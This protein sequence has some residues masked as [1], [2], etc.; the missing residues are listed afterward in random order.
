MK[1]HL[2][3]KWDRNEI[4]ELHDKLKGA[5]GNLVRP[6]SQ[7]GKQG[8]SGLTGKKGKTKYAPTIFL[9]IKNIKVL[10][11]NINKIKFSFDLDGIP[12]ANGGQGGLGGDG[13][14]G[15]NGRDAWNGPYPTCRRGGR[16]GGSG[17]SPGKGGR[18]GDAGCGGNGGR[19][20]LYTN[21]I[22][23]WEILYRSD[24][25]VKG[26]GHGKN[27]DFPGGK[28]GRPGAAGKPGAKGERGANA[29]NCSSVGDRGVP[30]KPSH[31][32]SEWRKW[33]LGNGEDSSYGEDGFFQ[34]QLLDNITN[35]VFNNK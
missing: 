15:V 28:G 17:G 4:H 7:R 8:P 32:S 34:T 6:I 12:G 13:T 31:G 2:V 27:Y 25:S 10:S 29:G 26:F 22:H 16:S 20:N 35:L 33:N 11:G 19:I 14:K 18:G 30:G 1:H 21:D 5:N 24:I 3:F 9:F 23:I